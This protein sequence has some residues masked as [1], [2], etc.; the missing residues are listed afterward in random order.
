LPD[1]TAYLA[2]QE[3]MRAQCNQSR[4]GWQALR[5]TETQRSPR[6]PQVPDFNLSIPRSEKIIVANAGVSEYYSLHLM[7][8]RT[9]C[10]TN[11]IRKPKLEGRVLLFAR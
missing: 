3:E 2:E 6:K 7:F 9:D 10:P 11:P 4:V 5:I 8:M 1:E